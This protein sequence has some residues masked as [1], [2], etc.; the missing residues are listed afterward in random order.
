MKRSVIL[1]AISLLILCLFVACDL[2]TVKHKLQVEV[3][4][5]GRVSPLAGTYEVGTVITFD[6]EPADGWIFS[7]W[8]GENGAEV[9]QEAGDWKI[10]MDGP[11]KLQ[12]IFELVPFPLKINIVG[13]GRVEQEFMGIFSSGDYTDYPPEARV[14]LRAL[15]AKGW[16][17]Q[18]WIGDFTGYGAVVMVKMTEAKEL[19]VVFE[20]DL[21]DLHLD[22]IG[23]GT[24]EREILPATADSYAY[25]SLVQL[26]AIA[27][28]G[29]EFIKWQGDIE[30]TDRE[31]R[32]L[33]DDIKRLTAVFSGPALSGY[34]TTTRGGPAVEGARVY[35]DGY[36][37]TWTDA[38]GYFVFD[39]V[40]EGRE[41]D[42]HIEKEGELR[43]V[44]QAIYLE[45]D[46]SMQLEIP[47]RE[48]FDPGMSKNPPQIIVDGVRR[49]DTISG[50]LHFDITIDGDLD[51]YVFYVYFGGGQ[52]NPVEVMVTEKNSAVV[53]IHT[54]DFVNGDHDIRVL[55]YDLNDNMTMLIIPVVVDNSLKEEDKIPDNL[56]YLELNSLTYGQTFGYYSQQRQEVFDRFGLPGDPNIVELLSGE[57]VDISSFPEHG[58]L[59]VRVMWDPVIGADGYHVYRSFDGETFK[60]IGDIPYG[61]QRLHPDRNNYFCYGYD[62]Y[63]PEL[64]PNEEVYYKVVPYNDAGAG[65]GL[66]GS[67]TPLPPFNV[68]LR[69]PAHN[70]YDIPL[71]P[72]FIWGP[73]VDWGADI[74]ENYT[75]LMFEGARPYYYQF[76]NIT[77][78]ELDFGKGGEDITLRPG[79]VYT[80]D[81]IEAIAYVEYK[82]HTNYYSVA[83]A[84]AGDG[85]GSWSGEAIFTTTT[86]LE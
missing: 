54:Q 25:E 73:D 20:R 42:L 16:A 55:A 14:K 36:M 34:V 72:K 7:G 58:T 5:E 39:Q 61:K 45:A 40:T 30:S 29:Y 57:K 75:F 18:E 56:D 80:W 53:D 4:G 49:G 84:I 70:A 51:S 13:E 44:V 83:Y 24:V 26:T 21:L 12:A 60:R 22:V 71:Q 10:L 15:P 1:A 66:V 35:I 2:F 50:T 47:V 76:G 65:N 46:E 69:Q 74:K 28:P 37:E 8:E 11:K 86:V 59:L 27:D 63:S 17:F 41:F 48:S 77:K 33:I 19:T 38:N 6:L 79:A 78:G 68:V 67:V 23:R 3:L 32:V 31:I 9:Q 52:R 85:R 81:I 82:N 62:D 43:A 64:T